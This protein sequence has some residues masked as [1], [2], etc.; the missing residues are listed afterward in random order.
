MMIGSKNVSFEKMGSFKRNV[1]S[2][3]YITYLRNEGYLQ[4]DGYN[5]G[6]GDIDISSWKVVD[7]QR[8]E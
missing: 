4:T 2:F 3:G 5:T 8:K 6:G 7:Y 1:N